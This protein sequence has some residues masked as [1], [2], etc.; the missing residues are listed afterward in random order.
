MLAYA[1][2]TSKIGATGIDV[3]LH[4]EMTHSGGRGTRRRKRKRRHG[5]LGIL[6]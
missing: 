2:K 4:R 3:S 1:Q 6:L 5:V